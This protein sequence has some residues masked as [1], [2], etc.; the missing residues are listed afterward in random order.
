MMAAFVTILFRVKIGR[1]HILFHRIRET[2]HV[3]KC[4]V[5]KSGWTGHDLF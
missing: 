1:F 4:I 5:I 3:L 2:G